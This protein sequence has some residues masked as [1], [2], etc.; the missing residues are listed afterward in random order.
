MQDWYHFVDVQDPEAAGQVKRYSARNTKRAQRKRDV[1]A[2]YAGLQRLPEPTHP[3]AAAIPLYY[4]EV[5]PTSASPGHPIALCEM[6]EVLPRLLDIQPLSVLQA[7]RVT[8]VS[9]RPTL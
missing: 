8:T 4:V 3:V 1:K 2:H 6:H 9:V 5:L 7:I